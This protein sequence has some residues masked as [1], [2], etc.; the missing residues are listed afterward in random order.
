[1]KTPRRFACLLLF[2][3]VPFGISAQYIS[4][5]G[6]L[7]PEQLVNDVLIDNPCAQVSNVSVQGWN[8]VNGDSYG[9][10]SGN[11]SSFPFANGV[12]LTTGR[13]VSAVGP[14]ATLLSEGP[15]S[16]PGDPDLEAALGVSGTINATILE[17]D[18]LPLAN[19]FSFDYI[20][21]SEQ[22]LTNPSAN[23]CNYTDGFA[24]LLKKAGS[25]GPYQ[26]L[27]VV[28][29]TQTPVRVNTVRGPGTLCPQANPQWF[30]AF[31]GTEHPTNYNGQTR[32][33][34]A[35]ATVEPGVLYHIKLVVADQGNNLYDSAIFLGGGSFKVQK[36]L[37]PD[38]LFALN[39]PLCPGETL[40]LNA[41]EPGAVSYQW[42][43]NDVAISGATFPEF[44]VTENGN[45]R[46]EIQLTSACESTGE[47]TVEY[48][49]APIVNSP[50]SIAV[51]ASSGNSGTFDLMASSGFIT[52][53]QPN[54]SG[55]SFY[56]SMSDAQNN[57]GAIQ[58]PQH[59]V[60]SDGTTVY[61]RV[62][63]L[64]GCPAFA[65][66]QLSANDAAPVSV[67][68]ISRCDADDGQTIFNLNT[69]VAAQ[70][71]TP[72]PPGTTTR[73]YATLA[74]AQ[75]QTA[76]LPNAFTNATSPQ[77][78]YAVFSHPT[79][80]FAITPIT[81]TVTVFSPP[82]FGR[83]TIALCPG[84][85]TA[86]S[87]PGQFLNYEWS[88]GEN[89]PSL[90]VGAAGVY[91]VTVTNASGCTATKTFDV[92]LID[93]AEYLG[94]S[95]REFNGTNNRIEV[96][97]SGS[98]A[99][100]FS[101]DG[102]NFQSNAVFTN[103]MPGTYSVFIR[104]ACGISGPYEVTILDYP[105]FFTPNADGTND[106]WQIPGLMPSD[107]ITIYDRYG[108]LLYG[109]NGHQPG[110]NGTFNSRGLPATDYWFVLQR[111]SGQTIKGHFSLIR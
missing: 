9:Y 72:L 42:F 30:D 91:S 102:V 47:I 25:S 60:A 43:Q 50:V 106:T 82:G 6:N 108:K 48:A 31:N 99:Y 61:A 57:V 15:T 34:T 24:F 26:N 12:V 13:A 38:R 111:A 56:E 109:F 27:A 55:L 88:G 79:T 8:T 52:G 7:T 22:Y 17:F 58:N 85:T 65:Q 54:L 14:N 69:D 101:I 95:T 107:Q 73:F 66:V 28:P 37:G 35:S 1:M 75:N 74:D 20:F 67:N 33:M 39:S 23:Q 93:P 96:L 29:G 44:T 76:E 104:D 19:K 63:N 94:I 64:Y 105:R 89:T 71:Q 90:Q 86:L 21:S 92:T 45:Y 100:E 81:L 62:E 78:I 36:N 32:I 97:Y 80:C 2:L 83:E 16:W 103:V 87:V 46:V 98:G 11:G 59:Y 10:F 77:T 51:C 41:T 40:T 84:E 5:S 53:N 49:N 70:L 4:V 110:W 3:L 18:F 68:P